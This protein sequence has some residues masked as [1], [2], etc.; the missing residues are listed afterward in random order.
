MTTICSR[1]HP[2]VVGLS[3]KDEWEIERHSI[4]FKKKIG[5]GSFGETWE[6]LWNQS[7]LVAVKVCK[8]SSINVHKL[9]AEI[10][11]W[12]KIHHD[13]IVQF[14]A[15]C[16]VGEPIFIITELV[17][18]GNLLDYLRRGEGR[19]LKLPQMIDIATQVASGMVYF[20]EQGYIHRDLAARNVLIDEGNIV[21]I[22]LSLRLNEERLAIKW[23][24][25]EVILFNKFTIRSD[26][27]SFGILIVELITHGRVPYPGM[28]NSEV[29]TKV[30][31][32]YRM[33]PPPRCPDPLYQIMVDCWK[34][35]PEERPTFEYLKIK[36]EDYF[37][38][39]ADHEYRQLT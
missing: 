12:K 20:E 4:T 14:Y 7:T 17:K 36:L 39:A 29:M 31:A 23:T 33:P 35:D 10:Q 32:G 38:S 37:V 1:V 26:V 16:T 5:I 28:T 18:N 6:G 19:L 24:A 11:I 34:Q 21:K 25:P 9:Q 3:Y 8:T 13:K 27:W 2:S 15:T 30:E 22:K